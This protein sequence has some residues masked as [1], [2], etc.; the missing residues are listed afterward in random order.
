MFSKQ[1]K[2]I[3]VLTVCKSLF[4]S[5]TAVKADTTHN[6]A[7]ASIA[8]NFPNGSSVSYHICYFDDVCIN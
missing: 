1:R 5:I 6:G 4:L 7:R 8:I 3:V 2:T